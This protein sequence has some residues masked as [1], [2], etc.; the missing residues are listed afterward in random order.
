MAV[1]THEGFN[2]CVYRVGLRCKNPSASVPNGAK[3]A[4]NGTIPFC[5]GNVLGCA[6]SEIVRT[7]AEAEAR[8]TELGISPADL[9]LGSSTKAGS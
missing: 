8:Q 1:P 3:L 9:R 2:I 5:G 7:L 6:G 4:E